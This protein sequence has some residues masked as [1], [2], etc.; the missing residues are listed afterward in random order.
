MATGP[1]ILTHRIKVTEQSLDF[2]PKEESDDYIRYTIKL[3]KTLNIADKLEFYFEE[4][5]F[6]SSLVGELY[7]AKPNFMMEDDRNDWAVSI[8]SSEDV[9]PEGNV[10]VNSF[11]VQFNEPEDSSSTGESS[12]GPVG[13]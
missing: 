12:E 2:A 4:D 11:E 6:F 7:N 9:S 8:L 3:E 13:E 1:T 10:L 5:L